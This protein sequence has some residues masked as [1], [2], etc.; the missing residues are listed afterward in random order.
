MVQTQLEKTQRNTGV[1]LRQSN[2]SRKLV[3]KHSLIPEEVSLVVLLLK[4][5][6]NIH[7]FQAVRLH[8]GQVIQ[9]VEAVFGCEECQ[10]VV[11]QDCGIVNNARMRQQ[12]H[13]VRQRKG[14]SELIVHDLLQQQKSVAA[15]GLR[16]VYELLKQLQSATVD[17]LMVYV[18]PEFRLELLHEEGD[19]CFKTRGMLGHQ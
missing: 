11:V 14:Q 16:V 2:C 9:Q 18:V 5:V 10:L 7:G 13:H 8:L 6:F 17:D 12:V 19:V 4:T 15:W 3:N 1:K